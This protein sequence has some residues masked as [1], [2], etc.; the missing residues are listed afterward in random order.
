MNEELMKILSELEGEEVT[1]SFLI[2][3]N[4]LKEFDNIAKTKFRGIK[5]KNLLDIALMK[6]ILD[7]TKDDKRE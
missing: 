2:N 7:T 5:K 3:K 4:V 1:R 6:F